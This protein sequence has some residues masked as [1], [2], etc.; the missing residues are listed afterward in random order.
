MNV[1]VRQANEHDLA[2][3][4]QLCWAYRDLLAERLSTRPEVLDAYYSEAKYRQLMDALPELHAR[5]DGVILV[6][7]LEGAVVGCGM[8]HRID[9]T[10]CE[11]KRV[12]VDASARGAGAGKT[13]VQAAMAQSQAD[14]Y[15]RMVLDTIIWL[16]E[17]ARLYEWMGFV[18]TAPYYDPDP[19]VLDLMLFMEHPL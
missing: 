1:S 19:E 7:E 16:P 12:F 13:L 14:G 3:V 9:A 5:P 4:R 18:P 17:A 6:A 8:T 11:I 2:T 10:T 15:T